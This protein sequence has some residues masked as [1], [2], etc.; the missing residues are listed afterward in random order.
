M[1]RNLTQSKHLPQVLTDRLVAALKPESAPYR[2]A[3]EGTG[4]F[5]EVMP[6]GL[7]VWRCLYE[8]DG[9][10]KQHK[11]GEYRSDGTGM[12]LAQARLARQQVRLDVQL[13]RDPALERSEAK[14][15]RI[16]RNTQTVEVMARE[17][18]AESQSRWDPHYTTLVL[19]RFERHVFPHIGKLPIDLVSRDDIIN[20]LVRCRDRK[21]TDKKGIKI[22]GPVVADEVRKHLSHAFDDWV[23]RGIIE[24]NPARRMSKRT[25]PPK[26]TPQPAVLNI[27][28]ARSLFR[29]FERSRNS[30]AMKLLHRFQ[31]LTAVRPNE[32]SEARWDEF[33][34]AGEWRIAADRMKGYTGKRRPHTV[35]L[36]P[37]AQEVVQVARARAPIDSEWV[38][39]SDHYLAPRPFHRSSLTK[40]M[41]E[42]YGKRVHVAH[43]WRATMGT[44]LE[45]LHRRDTDLIE[46]MLA[47]QTKGD[48]EGRYKRTDGRDFD[49]M[50][51]EF[52]AEWADLLLEGAPSPWKLAGLPEPQRA[53][54]KQPAKPDNVVAFKRRRAA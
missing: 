30:V 18:H 31:A 16:E 43:G 53:K 23:D 41:T 28:D 32:A 22:G 4:L 54:A 12:S 27:D 15:Q 34:V 40:C 3:D 25:A 46:I 5:V 20:L 11:L 17:W 19:K 13:G 51:R 37:Q 52:W 24:R 36:S 45:R 14:Q 48:V 21:G 49:T 10:R 47:H 38:F 6:S 44:V 42:T 39:P 8:R 9:K 35:Y 29:A 7:K 33:K 50:L 26:A 1:Q 2:Q